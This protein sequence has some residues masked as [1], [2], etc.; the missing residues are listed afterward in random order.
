ML[1]VMS[2]CRRGTPVIYQGQE[3]G[4]RN[5]PFESI[6]MYDDV[7]SKGEYAIALEHGFSEEEAL[8]CVQR[9]SRDNARY[10]VSWDASE[11]AGF[12]TG[13]PWLPV[14]PEHTTVNAAAALADPDSLYYVY[15]KLLAMRKDDEIG[16]VM[17][18]G[19]FNPYKP[20]QKDLVAY[21]RFMD[22]EFEA[23]SL[24]IL[25]NYQ[26]QSQTVE[27]PTAEYDVVYDNYKDKAVTGKSVELNPYEAV[28][29]KVK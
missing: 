11:N 15:K 21:T 12:T 14:A 19:K 29:I 9:R 25:C 1:A 3:F 13:K 2:M 20:E 17:V 5:F 18:F 22:E 26:G 27:I 6:D 24:L 23:G 16:E 8:K 4:M 10:P 28:I 7:S